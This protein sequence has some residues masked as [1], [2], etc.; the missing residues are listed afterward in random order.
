MVHWIS[1]GDGETR[2]GA[3][4][5]VVA[6]RPFGRRAVGGVGGADGAPPGGVGGVARLG[7]R[8]GPADG[9]AAPGRRQTGPAQAARKDALAGSPYLAFT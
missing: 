6:G 5:H 9:G 4:Q 8:R 2:R 7:R 3:Q 1:G